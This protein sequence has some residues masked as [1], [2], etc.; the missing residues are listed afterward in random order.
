MAL[1]TAQKHELLLQFNNQR[2][3]EVGGYNDMKAT[4]KAGQTMPAAAATMPVEGLDAPEEYKKLYKQLGTK[5]NN[6]DVRLQMQQRLQ[7]TIEA[8]M[9]PNFQ[10]NFN[11][12]YQLDNGMSN[13]TNR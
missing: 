5:N 9:S 11:A 3:R 8:P 12:G 7:G 10:L 4:R 13:T 2:N 6:K 1:T